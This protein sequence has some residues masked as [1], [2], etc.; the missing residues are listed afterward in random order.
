MLLECIDNATDESQNK[1]KA[2]ER[3]YCRT[4][5]VVSDEY[6]LKKSQTEAANLYQNYIAS[7]DLRYREPSG[8]K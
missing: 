5:C 8:S 2:T 4:I 7:F 6:K 1:T 3:L